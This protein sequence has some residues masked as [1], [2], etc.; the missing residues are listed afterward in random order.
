MSNRHRR[1]TARTTTTRLDHLKERRTADHPPAT[2]PTQQGSEPID[3]HQAPFFSLA[4]DLTRQVNKLTGHTE[5][6]NRDRYD[7]TRPHQS[8]TPGENPTEPR[9][10]L[11]GRPASPAGCSAAHSWVENRQIQVEIDTSV[12]S[13]V[14]LSKTSHS[15]TVFSR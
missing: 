9:N 7:T 8:R 10:K 14:R 6:P 2:Q 5:R 4:D 1:N 15:P 11:S 3:Q 12:I 13:F